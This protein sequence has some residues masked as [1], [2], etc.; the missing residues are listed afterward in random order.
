MKAIK[1][2]HIIFPEKFF[3]NYIEFVNRNFEE[4]D[5]LFISLKSSKQ[6]KQFSNLKYLKYYRWGFLYYWEMYKYV[7]K[8]DKVILHS[9]QKSKV[10]YFF[11]LFKKFRSKCYWYLWGG[12][13]YY[14]LDKQGQANLLNWKNRWFG[15]LV[16]DLGGI[17]THF[18]GDVD[19]AR[20]AFSFCGE[21]IHCFL[22]PSNI[23][24]GSD[25]ENKTSSKLVIQVGNSSHVS[26]SH[27]E[28]LEKL[29]Y[30]KEEDIEIIC[31]LSYGDKKNAK[32]IIGM[33][34]RIFGD[35]FT[36]I[37]NFM[38]LAAYLDLIS[39]VDI[40][41]FNHWRQQGSGNLISLVGMGKT[42]YIREDISTWKMFQDL[43]IKVISFNNF[44]Q[45]ELLNADEKRANNQIISNYFNEENLRIQSKNVFDHNPVSK[46]SK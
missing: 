25:L 6:Y 35:K 45:V 42:V 24:P 33:G 34:K 38:P 40:A 14:R 30:L 31:P 10:I 8:S 12:D 26:N 46:N 13:L 32:K 2:L 1:T 28:V 4:E 5:H 9:L 23:F 36:A 22:Y 20:K 19:L 16:R 18:A 43:G 17:A 37:T 21:H 27:E 7:A 15:S 39:K 29:A 11:Y 44:Q 41:I 3:N